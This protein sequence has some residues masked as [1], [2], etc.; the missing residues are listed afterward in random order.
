M[1]LCVVLFAIQV[2]NPTSLVATVGYFPENIIDHVRAFLLLG[3]TERTIYSLTRPGSA[4][5][6]CQ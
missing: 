2:A 4:Y 1:Q 3:F 6:V 5:C